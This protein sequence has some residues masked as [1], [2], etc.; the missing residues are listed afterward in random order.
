MLSYL[1][2]FMNIIGPKA[3][4]NKNANGAKFYDSDITDFMRWG[5]VGFIAM[6]LY[7]M[8]L[9]LCTR[10]INPSSELKVK[11]ESLNSDTVIRDALINI[12]RYRELVPW[13]FDGA[14]LNIDK[15]LFLENALRDKVILPNRKDK[16][17][18]FTYFRVGL[19]RLNEFQWTVKSQM[20]NE[21]GLAVNLYVQKVYKQ[22]QKHFLNCLA[23]T[24]EFKV[25]DYIERAENEVKKVME[26]SRLCKKPKTEDRW[27]TTKLVST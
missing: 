10:S 1:S 8:G 15:L 7:Q 6:G 14:V 24:G 18:A 23:L 12:Q 4:G 2:T 5:S 16:A 25:D 20:G 11:T 17:I 13:L 3:S 9:K 19:N 26:D 27:T 21:H 22:L